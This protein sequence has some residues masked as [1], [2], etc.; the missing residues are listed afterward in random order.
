[1]HGLFGGKRKIIVMAKVQQISEITPSFAFTEFDFYKDY[2]ESFKKSELGR[3]HSLLPLHEMAIIFGLID[4]YPRK[5]VGRK[6]YFSPKGKLA[7][8]FLKSYTG[9]SAPKLM[10]QLNANIHYQLFCGIRISS[11]NPL[12]NYKLIDDII[13]E[14]S[15]RLRIQNQQEA[16]AEAWKPYMKNLDTLYTDATCYESAMRYPTDAKLLWEC[17]E[18][19]YPMMCKA[20]RELGIHRMRTKYLD[21]A[22]DNMVYVKQRRHT[23][24]RTRKI[25]RRLLDLLGKILAELRR[26]DRENPCAGLFSDKQLSEIETIT[27]VYR[28]QR[29]HHKSGNAKESIPHRIVSVNKPYVRPIVR[30]KEVK[31]VEFGAKCN[32]ILVDGMSF[33]EKI[34]FNAFNEGT[35]LEHCVKLAEKLFGEKIT[36]LG[37]DC[38]YSGNDNRSFCSERG[39]VT[40]FAQKGK[41]REASTSVSMVK[42]E[43]ARVR[44]TAMEGSFGTQKEHYGLKRI[45]GRIKKTEVLIIFF[46]IH[47]ANAVQ[48][49]RRIAKA[50]LSRAA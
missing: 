24:Q 45:N 27:K 39:I 6:S 26:L 21:V 38:S 42:K 7:L 46:G 15:N 19:V 8:M 29:N 49:A 25:I 30:G 37:G 48:L 47:T 3:I 20:S 11:A 13:L 9:L 33:I 23:K 34:S 2:E 16:L 35:R 44:A 4:P 43:L 28:Q 1:M 18:K 12:T 40:S 10:E 17:I 14:L 32:N 5:K 22:R 31:K 41:N 50:E 36:K